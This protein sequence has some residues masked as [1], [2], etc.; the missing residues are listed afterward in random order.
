[1][2]EEK[3]LIKIKKVFK[4]EIEDYIVINDSYWNTVLEV[5]KIWI[6]R[7][8]K[9]E[10]DIKQLSIE[11]LFLP[12]IYKLSSIEI[13]N[14]EYQG[15]DFIGYRKIIGVPFSINIYDILS[16]DSKS[17]I[18]KSIWDFL[19]Q[20]HSIEF[21]DNNLVAFP[22]WDNDFWKTLWDPIESKLNIKSRKNAFK[23][24]SDYFEQVSKSSIRLTICHA[25]F[26]PN[27]LLY[28]SSSKSISGIIDFGRLSINDPAIDF[29][30]IERFYGNNAV[31]EILKH[32]KFDTSKNFRE[33]IT[34]QNRRRLFAAIHIAKIVGEDSQLPRYIKRIDDIFS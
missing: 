24:F 26:H 25:D 9:S 22:Y 10:I 21:L 30:L 17:E 8:S 1:M 34:F 5:N 27:H 16:S 12:K 15:K 6:F 14:I 32:Y 31:T 23:Y 13:P 7:F 2:T 28:D 3:Y 4:D 11:K 29:N 20:L 18:W 19:T 33:R